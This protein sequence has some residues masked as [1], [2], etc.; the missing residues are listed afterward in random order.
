MKDTRKPSKELTDA[1][2]KA[3]DNYAGAAIDIADDEKVTPKS[4]KERTKVINLNPRNQD[5]M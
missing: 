1:M 3:A 4:V 5:M 2:R